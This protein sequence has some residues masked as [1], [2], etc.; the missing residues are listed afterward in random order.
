LIHIFT[1]CGGNFFNLE[2]FIMSPN[3]PDDYPTQKNCIWTI[4]VP[5]S[6]QIELNITTFLLEESFECGFDY[7]E[8]R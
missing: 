3:F 1:V 4:N 8:I 2:G 7:V 6:N 5:V